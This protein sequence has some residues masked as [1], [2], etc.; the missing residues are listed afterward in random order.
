[1]T[2]LSYLQKYLQQTPSALHWNKIGIRDHHGIALPL[3][4][5]HSEKS[6]K[7]GEYLDLLPLIDWVKK[8]GM[9]VIQL[10]PL[11][12]TGDDP[13]PYNPISALALH[14]IYLSL[15]DLPYV[16][17]NLQKQLEILQKAHETSR[18][19]YPKVKKEKMG[20]LFEYFKEVYPL[21]SKNENLQKFETQNPWLG[22]YALYKYLREEKFKKSWR[23]WP[24]NWKKI[25]DYS[26]L[27]NTYQKEMRF[28]I[29]LQFLCF[30]QM[31]KV[32]N[33]AQDRSVLLQG[34]IPILLSTDS[35]DIWSNRKLFHLDLSA[36]A[37][38][39]AY[40]AEGQSWGFPIYNWP[41]HELSDY[42]WWKMRLHV[43]SK[44]YHIYRIDHVVGFFRMWAIQKNC[45]ALQGEFSPKNLYLWPI[46]G[47]KFL[48]LLLQQS[49]LL[50][51]AEDL[52][53]I[54]PFV[55]TTLKEL[56]IAGTSVMRWERK[57]DLD[58]EYIA[59]SEYRPLSVTC[60]GTHD[61]EPLSV[62]W[63]S[64]PLD[65]KLFSK[66]LYLSYTPKFSH[67]L[68][69]KILYASHHSQSLFHINPLQEYLA[70]FPELSRK[71]QEEERINIPGTSSSFN[72]TYRF[73]PSIE[74]I[75]T[76][77]KFL[78]TMK[79]IIE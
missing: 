37:P 71:D 42:R 1:M 53:T 27:M 35:A 70:L 38:P 7:I 14:P 24:E 3:F 74:E 59:P 57:W 65:A 63:D 25:S 5:L 45:T 55:F 6:C 50:P 49:T 52:G 67:D 40:S 68:R 11:Q 20:W 56:G 19:S 78:D 12:D 13:S 17:G 54:P 21:Y 33:Y 2:R 28:F 10:L 15:H 76:H 77:T 60:V 36:G 32:C 51:L 62:W 43:A 34:D 23:Q 9:D 30:S 22:I 41:E 72:W 29:F 64:Y 75:C 79:K 69:K 73:F 66:S 31:E 18:I 46:L 4:S 8:I 26:S 58:G 47:K 16:E 39:D 48:Q 44:I 61:S